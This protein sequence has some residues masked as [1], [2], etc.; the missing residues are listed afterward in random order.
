MFKF[1][2]KDKDKSKGDEKKKERKE[3][4]KE[5]KIKDTSPALDETDTERYSPLRY[6][7]PVAP[8]PSIKN[9]KPIRT[10]GILKIR[11]SSKSKSDHPVASSVADPLQILRENT[12]RNEEYSWRNSY[13]EDAA[14]GSGKR[15]RESIHS[16]TMNIA[17]PTV[18]PPTSPAEKVYGVSLELPD[19]TA[20]PSSNARELT[21]PRQPKGDF[22]FNLRWAPYK[23]GSRGVTRQVVHAEPGSSGTRSGIITGDRVIEVNGKNVEY[24]S[25]E[26][27][28]ALVHQSGD[29]V[30]LKVQQ[31]AE[32][33]ELNMRS[34]GKGVTSEEMIKEGQA[35]V[36]GHGGADGFWLV[37]RDGYSACQLMQSAT[38][39]GSRCKVRLDK[40]SHVLEV[41]ENDLERSNPPSLDLCENLSSLTYLNES[42]LLH[43]LRQ[44][45]GSSLIHTVTGPS[46]LVVSPDVALNIYSHKIMQM[47]KGCHIA[48]LPPHV[49]SSAQ[50]A[51]QVMM[52][53]S[54]DQ[55]VV[56]GGWTGSGKTTSFKHILGYYA[57]CY[58]GMHK[59]SL[60]EKLTAACFVLESLGNCPTK[61]NRNATRFSQM[62]TLDFDKHGYMN[63]A[64]FQVTMLDKS[65]IV[66]SANGQ[67]PFHI[68]NYVAHGV[69]TAMT[70]DLQLHGSR[71]NL[72]QVDKASATTGWSK[73]DQ[74]LRVLAITSDES[75]II[76]RVVAAIIHLHS[77]G[78]AY[79]ANNKP[80][81]AN[82]AGAQAACQL[83]GVTME[84][85]SKAIF[86]PSTNASNLRASDDNIPSG[87][88]ALEGFLIG[89][90]VEL[91]NTIIG[92]VNR[93]L[94]YGT[95]HHNS[96]TLVDTPGF[97]DDNSQ[98]AT[99][100]DLCYNYVNERLQLLFYEKNFREKNERYIQEG[101]DVDYDDTS[102]S[103]EAM[104]NLIDKCSNQLQFQMG[105]SGSRVDLSLLGR[106]DDVGLLWI[107][108]EV[109][110]T[111]GAADGDFVERLRE[112]HGSSSE[113]SLLTLKVERLLVQH[114]KKPTQ[115][116][117]NHLQG[118]SP[119]TY[120]TAGW[121][122]HCRNHPSAE[123]AIS[124]LASSQRSGVSDMFNSMT[125]SMVSSF[126]S[127]SSRGTDTLRG[128]S[129]A[130]R[131]IANQA[132]IKRRSQAI[133]VKYQTD[134]LIDSLSNTG[135][136]FINHL[137]ANEQRESPVAGVLNVPYVR[138]QIRALQLLPAIRFY[139]QGYPE[140]MV[141]SDFISRYSLLAEDTSTHSVALVDQKSVVQGILSKVEIDSSYYRV[142]LS[143]V[144]L[145]PAASVQ[146]DRQRELRRT[147]YAVVIQKHV[148]RYLA[149]KSIVKLRLKHETM[150]CVQK[151]IRIYFKLR[152]WQWWR[153]Y[154]KIK[155][156]INVHQTEH[157]LEVKEKELKDLRSKLESV[158]AEKKALKRECNKFEDEVVRFQQDLAQET[159]V[160]RQAVEL[161]EQETSNRLALE[162]QLLEVQAE[163]VNIKH[164]VTELEQE[165]DNLRQVHQDYEDSNPDLTDASHVA[166]FKYEHT[167]K[168]QQIRRLEMQ[169]QHEQALEEL[170][171]AKHKSDRQLHEM[172]LDRDELLQ[173]IQSLKKKLEKQACDAQ[174]LRR[175]CEESDAR[176]AELEKR[177]RRFDNELH[178]HADDIAGEKAR[179]DLLQKERDQLL[180]HKYAV[181]QQL[182]DITIERDA[183]QS[184]LKRLEHEMTELKSA[185]VGDSELIQLR[186]CKHDLERKLA[187]SEDDI[188]DLQQEMHELEMTKLKLQME[189]DKMKIKQ[190]KELDL[191]EREMD[192]LREAST[193]K[194]RNYENRIAELDEELQ[195]ALHERREAERK[196]L[197]ARDAEPVRDHEREKEL[198]I[199]IRRLRC[200]LTDS[201][202][203][204]EKIKEQINQKS[205]MRTMETKLEDLQASLTATLKSKHSLETDL[206]E[207]QIQLG[208]ASKSKMEAED[209]AAKLM[210]DK[211]DIENEKEDLD[212][213]IHELLKRYQT[214][215]AQNS[216]TAMSVR[217]LNE[218]V[219][220]LAEAKARLQEELDCANSKLA[221]LDTHYVTKDRVAVLESKCLEVEQKLDY[222]KSMRTRFENQS[223]KAKDHSEKLE[224][225][226]AKLTGR[227]ADEERRSRQIQSQLSRALESADDVHRKDIEQTQIIANMNQRLELCD[228]EI[229]QLQTELKSA[230]K[231]AENLQ[232]TLI[233]STLSD[234]ETEHV[235]EKRHGES[236]TD[237]EGGYS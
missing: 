23:D 21:V 74:S 220:T 121:I 150:K 40:G 27:V 89:L 237:S 42:S 234:D 162:S 65:R 101:I 186:T 79:G 88:D 202:G 85:I 20:S 173:T 71:G 30:R 8:K 48:D 3:S 164:T 230:H 31:V 117:L 222:E 64:T 229:R 187:E 37:H 146:L 75:K 72:E 126:T 5:R 183:L 129:S 206:Q 152:N 178:Q 216:S 209:R 200:L 140:H 207:C 77:A 17:P 137:L 18:P 108:D 138:V 93:S 24:D 61:H 69:S 34:S 156:L 32:V 87:N 203:Q 214:L 56:L 109:A 148:R 180:K 128:M 170:Q 189:I 97:N 224:D 13:D 95:R 201:Q 190:Q 185:C 116:T 168:E 124:L 205:Q 41:D 228:V 177:H 194:T 14:H 204:L 59:T 123:R 12:R 172:E 182:E 92:L 131:L 28:I 105:G 76:Q 15:K 236:D 155:P 153:L 188:G 211:T 161:L 70:A 4:K 90:Y 57:H 226:I 83:L 44:R 110:M 125:G 53:T 166:L 235:Q 149:Q 1:G 113:Q 9:G 81:F 139:R 167:V 60:D 82:P 217:D 163:T 43:V 210:R 45:S 143:Q 66:M 115:V 102:K 50:K 25:R 175:R 10:K 151:N 179:R 80:Y 29:S 192:E 127:T 136:H 11:G 176:S 104:V 112:R 36:N 114:K 181:S 199:V 158:E 46:L 49:Y 219:T 141:F 111:P 147:F 221:H 197:S 144:F 86:S 227:I 38:G 130:R 198:K 107:L 94:S 120:E 78:V 169:S 91:C 33:S 103:P 51:Y 62:I 132:G 157:D 54:R 174:D 223:L 122:K 96:I 184:K 22:G 100:A 84:E 233:Q 6:P 195:S 133:L 218:Q 35:R 98:P 39:D 160:A 52:S 134:S 225:E 213:E 119:V 19:L 159:Q 191:L 68:F 2:R 16:I 193:R 145:R 73:L 135:I 215:V 142:G 231:R 47:V 196:L 165:N 154:T 232:S 55:T 208:L 26:D 212:E 63:S 7:P 99:F 67:S 106:E 118:M 171:H 58:G